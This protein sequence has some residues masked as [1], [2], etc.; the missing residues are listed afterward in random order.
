VGTTFQA[1]T[2]SAEA[3]DIEAGMYDARYDEVEAKTLEKSQFD[4]NVY[5]WGFTLFEDGK[6]I[7][8]KGEPVEVDKVTSQSTNV[9]SKTTPGA[10]KVLKALMTAEEF[11]AFER[12]ETIEAEELVGRMVQVQV[13]IKEN[14]WPTVEEVLPA[15]RARR[16]RGEG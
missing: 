1:S 14:G 10:V 6:V 4:P 2:S 5:I 13:I 3:P 11:A 16:S 9:K 7:Y 12:G 8:D 15:R